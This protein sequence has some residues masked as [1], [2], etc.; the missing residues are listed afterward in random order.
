MTAFV[1]GFQHDL[2]I[3]YAHED[4]KRW[5]QAFE[6]ELRDEVS[7]RLGMGISVWQDTSHIRFGEN[8]QAA[9]QEGIEGTAAF[10]AIVSPRYQNSQWCARERNKF[11]RR[12]KPEEF[13]M[14]GRFFKAVKTPWPDN[15]HRFFLQEIQAVD[16]CKDG[17]DGHIE[18]TPGSRDFKRAVRKLADGVELL[19]RR[20]R[21]ANQRVHVAWPVEE[22]L[23]AWEQLSDE[24]RSKGF[25]VQPMGPRNDSF[26]DNLLIQDIDQAVLSIHLLGSVY[27]EFSERV[28]LLAADLER[29]MMFWI[30][31][32]ADQTTDE[33]QRAL[34]DAIRRGMRPDKPG[35]EWPRGW[36]LVADEGVRG[37]IDAVI[38]KL[39][40]RPSAADVLVDDASPHN[41][42]GLAGVADD[43]AVPL[44]AADPRLETGA[45]EP[46][47]RDKRSVE[48]PIAERR[49]GERP[50]RRAKR[51]P[52]FLDAGTTETG[53]VRRNFHHRRRR[54]QGHSQSG[55]VFRDTACQRI[56]SFF[57]G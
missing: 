44:P 15:A 46:A 13:G 19:L 18:F 2:F 27:D 41:L 43:G 14:S 28:A 37:L 50:P 39:A 54:G 21:R 55:H 1:P 35:A 20:M 16:F 5:V 38:T 57:A 25:D 22:C 31:S 4:D 7:R 42:Q 34:I 33:R 47:S 10:V 8:W 23:V 32:G 53:E 11:R 56:L 52:N 3:S 26:A 6:D 17:P 9:I 12:F 24:L 45:I 51:E 40:H 48:S 29:E 49:V 30:S 36:S